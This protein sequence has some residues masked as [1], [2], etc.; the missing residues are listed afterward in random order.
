MAAMTRTELGVGIKDV[1]DI[2]P[3]DFQTKVQQDAEIIKAEVREGTF[4]NPQ[5]LVGLEYEFYGTTD[6]PTTDRNSNTSNLQQGTLRR[7]PRRTLSFIG[8]EK[9]LGLHNNF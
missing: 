8:L 6:G 4:D 9:E 5:G 2:S 1:L 3:D 7:I